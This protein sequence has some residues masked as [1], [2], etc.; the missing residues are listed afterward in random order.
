MKVTKIE[1]L[2]QLVSRTDM[3]G[4]QKVEWLTNF[5]DEH[6]TEQLRLNDVSN[7]RELL[8]DF[9]DDVLMCQDEGATI[10]DREKYVDGYLGN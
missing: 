1:K 8:I 6:V 7:R 10:V 5:I 2:N 9:L 4:N 3:T